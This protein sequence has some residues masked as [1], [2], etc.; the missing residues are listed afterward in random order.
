MAQLIDQRVASDSAATESADAN[1]THP[2]W[3]DTDRC[4][5]YAPGEDGEAEAGGF[6]ESAQIVVDT[7]N[8][9]PM[10]LH[11][12]LDHGKPGAAPEVILCTGEPDGEE[13][14]HL[15]LDQAA[16][17]YDALRLLVP[18]LTNSSDSTRVYELGVANGR[19]QAERAI[20]VNRE[21]ASADTLAALDRV[22]K[23][24]DDAD[25]AAYRAY[26][27]GWVDGND[28]RAPEFEVAR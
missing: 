26:C 12:T 19:R 28:G 9:H 27:T 25:R 11:L 21:Q 8:P 1:L 15:S 6:H 13:C 4:W 24:L 22:K 16:Q 17:L 10:S 20:P 23:R 5:A 7:L 2:E 3:C 18:G 14:R